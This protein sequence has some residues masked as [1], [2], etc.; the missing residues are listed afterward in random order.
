MTR[1][2]YPNLIY[3]HEVDKGEHLRL[4]NSRNSSL[5][6]SVPRFDRSANRGP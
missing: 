6:R 2:A 4:G 3:F 5:K 1:R